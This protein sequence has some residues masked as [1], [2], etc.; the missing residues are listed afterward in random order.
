MGSKFNS[1]R[2]K[3][4]FG[5][6]TFKCLLCDVLRGVCSKA[7]GAVVVALADVVSVGGF[8]T[9]IVGDD[10]RR[11]FADCRHSGELLP[12]AATVLQRRRLVPRGAPLPV[13]SM[14]LLAQEVSS[15]LPIDIYLSRPSRLA[16]AL[17]FTPASRRYAMRPSLPPEPRASRC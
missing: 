4:H 6:S 15:L 5:M 8:K 17:L 2:Y 9:R 1:C 10:L 11:L 13:P 7:H 16:N 12:V 14:A 3:I